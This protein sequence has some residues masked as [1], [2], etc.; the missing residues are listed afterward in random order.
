VMRHAPT[1]LLQ[2]VIGVSRAVGQTFKGVG[3]QVDREHIKK[4]EDV[5]SFFSFPIF[6]PLSLFSCHPVCLRGLLRH[7]EAFCSNGKC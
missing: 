3:N 2:P 4:S 6:S 7:S 1:I 5:S